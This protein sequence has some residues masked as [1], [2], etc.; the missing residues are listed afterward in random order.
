MLYNYTLEPTVNTYSSIKCTIG[1]KKE[2]INNNNIIISD[3]SPTFKRPFE[4]QQEHIEISSKNSS[5]EKPTIHI[6]KINI[7]NE[8]IEKVEI[9]D[10]HLDF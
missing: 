5:T 1:S 2:N 7:S 4:I 8:K 10:F 6:N 9:N 3:N